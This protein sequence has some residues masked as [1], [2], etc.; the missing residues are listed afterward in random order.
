MKFG[1]SVLH[2]A[3]QR[4]GGRGR[5]K[6]RKKNVSD[7]QTTPYGRCAGDGGEKQKRSHTC[8]LT[9]DQQ[10]GEIKGGEVS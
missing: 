3:E 4:W 1:E 5:G 2:L 10:R 8:V 6:G 9:V 7:E